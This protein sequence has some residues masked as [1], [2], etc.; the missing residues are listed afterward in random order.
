MARPRIVTK[1]YLKDKIIMISMYAMSS[2]VRRDEKMWRNDVKGAS[3]I[4]MRIC[5][6]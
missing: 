3:C 5:N 4:A 1:K 6:L 2:N